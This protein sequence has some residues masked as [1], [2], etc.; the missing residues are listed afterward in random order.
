MRDINDLKQEIISFRRIVRPQRAVLGDLEK[1]KQR[2]LAPDDLEIYFDDIVDA[3]ERIWDI[4]ENYKEVI[5]S[6][7]ATNESV[8][9]HRL[10]DVHPRP[11]RVT[12]MVL[13]V[14]L[15]A[16]IWG[17]N[18]GVP[19]EGGRVRLL[20]GA[21]R[22][23]GDPGRDARLLPQARL[24]VSGTLVSVNA[25]EFQ[26]LQMRGRAVKTGIF[27]RPLAGRVVVG[28][29]GLAGDHVA[30]RRY[31][32]GV[33]K[34]LYAYG[35]EDYAWWAAELGREWEPGLFGENLTVEGVDP[36]HAEIGERWRIGTAVVEVSEP[37]EPCA[38]LATKLGER[39]FVKRFAQAL[40]LGAYMR[41]IE[42]GALAAGD[43][44]EVIERPGHGVTTEMLGRILFGEGSLAPRALDASAMSAE[45]RRLVEQRAAK[46]A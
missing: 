18:V 46:S 9:S 30:D 8:L 3:A 2:Y 44:V 25:A 45:W 24:A 28:A 7:E 32:G 38:K 33:D 22:D 43:A 11:Q 42:P 5:D 10:N 23:G 35:T 20:P 40:R 4:L 21:R 29:E 15:I 34:A 19:G 26:L 39:G 41:V 6:L 31:H 1:S 17:M 16:S 27:K 13:P 14:T 36:S 12:V 37:R